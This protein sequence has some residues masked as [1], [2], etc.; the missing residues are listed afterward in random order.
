MKHDI[1]T[2]ERINELASFDEIIDVRSPA[3]FADDHIP[4]S[5]NCP[6]LDDQQR[7]EVG[8][9][10][11]QVSPFA[12]KKVGA[13]HVAENIAKHLQARF[14]DRPKHWRPLIV[15]WRGGQRSGSMTYVF[16]RIGWDAQQ[17]EGGYRTYRRLVIA[18][19]SEV[20]RRLR[21]RVIC[22]A[23]GSGKSRILQAIGRLGEQ[24]LDLEEL[25]CHK[26][27]V[28]GVL[29]DSP[30]PSQKMFESRL[31][32]AVYGFDCERPV[33]VEAESRKIGSLHL[34]TAMIETMRAG[35]CVNIEASFGARVDFL[36]RDYDYFLAAPEWLNT[37][38]QPLRGLHSSETFLRWRDYAV[39]GQW[40][41]LVTELLEQHYD[42]L[43]SRSQS[44]NY[45]GFEAPQ[46]QVT[47]DLTPAGIEAVARRVCSR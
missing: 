12:A 27:S 25:A 26:G 43:Y 14:L 36:L 30:Q 22:G 23:T 5:I 18:S 15:C 24:I 33:Y 47:D 41:P 10:Y 2:V 13:A 3:E 35:E 20:P 37:C 19:L 44:R 16:R 11:K 32:T 31:L 29:P 28:L 6:V 39:A 1:A 7:V 21:L 17:L 45:A 34:P 40:R 4:G 38:L 42:P 8:T 9:L 46:N